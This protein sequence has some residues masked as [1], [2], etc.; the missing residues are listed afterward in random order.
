VLNILIYIF[1]VADFTA[2]FHLIWFVCF[3]FFFIDDKPL[4]YIIVMCALWL[5]TIVVSVIGLFS[6]GLFR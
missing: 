6:F 2:G 4:M 1:L 3:D 5:V